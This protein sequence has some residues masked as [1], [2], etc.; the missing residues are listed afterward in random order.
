MRRSTKFLLGV[1]VALVT[2]SGLQIA[3]GD[4]YH[5]QR[6]GERH[7]GCGYH[8]GWERFHERPAQPAP[9]SGR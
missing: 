8:G 5:H 9:D 3:W 2:A 1:A 4:R 7:R 6:F